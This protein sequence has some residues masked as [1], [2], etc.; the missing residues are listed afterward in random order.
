M[1]PELPKGKEVLTLVQES[2]FSR[3]R[4]FVCVFVNFPLFLVV[5]AI[6]TNYAGLIL[7]V[8]W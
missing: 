3:F 6:Y 5:H 7:S 1:S 2:N 4:G 8:A